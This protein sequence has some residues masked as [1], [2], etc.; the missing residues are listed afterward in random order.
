MAWLRLIQKR[1]RVAQ[2]EISAAELA[3]HNEIGDVWLA[4]NGAVYDVS[5]YVDFHPGGRDEMMRGAGRDA[6]VLFLSYHSWVNYDFLLSKY[7]LGDL[8]E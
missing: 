1:V 2:R 3:I 6:T 4:L 5:H 8:V 7:R